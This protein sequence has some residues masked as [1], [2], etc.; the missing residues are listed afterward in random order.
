MTNVIH[1]ALKAAKMI[2]ENV[3]FHLFIQET[4]VDRFAPNLVEQVAMLM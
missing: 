3:I 2:E 4:L 1:Y